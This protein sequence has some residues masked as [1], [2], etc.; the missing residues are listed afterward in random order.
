PRRKLRGR[1][2]RSHTRNDGR[3]ETRILHEQSAAGARAQISANQKSRP[4]PH[5]SGK[6]AQA[7]FP[8]PHHRGP[9]R[10]TYQSPV[11]PTRYGREDVKMVT[12]ALGVR[13][14]LREQESAQSPNLSRLRGGNDLAR[15][16]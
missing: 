12:R 10:S 13:H 3:P 4:R 16:A 11:C 6:E 2:R 7:V 14:T 9:N 5:N 1:Q 8:C 15:A